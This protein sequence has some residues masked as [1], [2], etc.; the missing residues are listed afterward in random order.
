MRNIPELALTK[1]DEPA[2]LAFVSTWYSDETPPVTHAT[3]PPLAAQCLHRG[4][5]G[6]FTYALRTKQRRE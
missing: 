6:G 4:L 2:M 1:L 5:A 3:L